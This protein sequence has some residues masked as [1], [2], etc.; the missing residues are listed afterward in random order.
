MRFLRV[1]NRNIRSREENGTA[2]LIFIYSITRA[3]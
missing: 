1:M 3:I 2:R